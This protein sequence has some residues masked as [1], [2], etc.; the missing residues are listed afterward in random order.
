MSRRLIALS[1]VALGVVL[2]TG[3]TLDARQRARGAPPAAP[4]APLFEVHELGILALQAAQTD[5]TVTARGLVQSYLARIAAYDQAG[6][7][8]SVV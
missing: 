5:G 1:L 8:K 2:V 4:A 6:D 3:P 7:R